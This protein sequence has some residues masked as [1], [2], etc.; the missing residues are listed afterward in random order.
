MSIN[1]IWMIEAAKFDGYTSEYN[2]DIAPEIGYFTK[3]VDAETYCAHHNRIRWEEYIGWHIEGGFDSKSFA[4]E[5][6]LDSDFRYYRVMQVK[7]ANSPDEE[8]A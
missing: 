4:Y 5:E 6:W 2:Y 3:K 1:E 7:P 8:G